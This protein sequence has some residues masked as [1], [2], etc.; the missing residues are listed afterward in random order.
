MTVSSTSGLLI[1]VLSGL[2]GLAK[3]GHIRLIKERIV[4]MI[5]CSK[6]GAEVQDGVELCPECGQ[7]VGEVSV[8]Q[9]PPP[10]GQ[11]QQQYQQPEPQAAPPPYQQASPPPYQQPGQQAAPPPYQQ[12]G[13]QAGQPPPYQ[14]QPYQQQYQQQQYQQPQYQQQQNQQGFPQG[15]GTPMTGFAVQPHNSSLG[16]EANVAVLIIAAAMIVMSWIPFASWVTFA[17]P[18]IFFLL[19]KQSRFVKFEA[20]QICAIGIVRAVIA[21]IAQII[22]WV[23]QSRVVY[24]YSYMISY[25]SRRVAGIMAVSIVAYI[26][27]AILSILVIYIGYKGYT[28]RQV[29]LPGVGSLA[30]NMSEK[31]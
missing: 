20:V 5:V 1:L 13:Q 3:A 2:N 22:I 16:M 24:S 31:F 17:V 9:P 8:Q 21:I 11:P 23:I 7:T 26:I 14:Q 15:G 18:L 19:E 12:P 27:T 29:E 10:Q 28:Y 30:K 6:C 25:Y 4:I